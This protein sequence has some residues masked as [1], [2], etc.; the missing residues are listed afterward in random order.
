MLSSFRHK[1]TPFIHLCKK[2]SIKKINYVNAA[3][4]ISKEVTNAMA[5][6]Y[7]SI[8]FFPFKGGGRPF[9]SIKTSNFT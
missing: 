5:K 9:L 7:C 4:G 8:S 3:I 6:Y 2:K 1:Y